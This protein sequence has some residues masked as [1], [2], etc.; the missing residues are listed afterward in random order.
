PRA[1]A[2]F[3]HCFTCGKNSLAA[4]RISRALAERGI[5]TLRF[6]FTGLGESGGEFGDAGFAAD[7]ADLV[8]AAHWLAATHG[9]PSL[10]L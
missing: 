7:V 3:A 6:D 2:I 5:A 9:Q 4:T 10:L 1:W 8:A